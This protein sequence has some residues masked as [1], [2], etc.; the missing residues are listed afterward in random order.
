MRIIR[1]KILPNSHRLKF[2]NRTLLKMSVKR[3]ILEAKTDKELEIYLQEDTRFV[4]QAIQFAYEILKSRGRIFTPEEIEQI[5]FLIE[6]KSRNDKIT[7]HP[8]HK[9]AAN[10]IYASAAL[11]I[12]N[13]IISPYVNFSFLNI[14]FSLIIVGMIFGIGYIVSKGSNGVKYIIFAMMIIGLMYI[15]LMMSNIIQNPVVG[16][17][18]IMQTALQIWAL[19]LLFQIPKPIK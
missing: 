10:L 14:F 11:S 5:T 16:T 18:N 7:I 4:P 15:P 17:I 19:I 13:I 6:E 9:K 1:K 12:V 3:K 2:K 8:N